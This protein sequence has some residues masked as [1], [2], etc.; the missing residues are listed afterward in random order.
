VLLRLTMPSP[1]DIR[2]L[3]SVV[4]WE[5]AGAL[6]AGSWDVAEAAADALLAEVRRRRLDGGEG[7]Q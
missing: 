5:V 6:G 4:I 2:R 3:V 1:V 7:P